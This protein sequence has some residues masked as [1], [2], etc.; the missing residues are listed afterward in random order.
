M[1]LLEANFFVQKDLLTWDKEHFGVG[2]FYRP[3]TEFIIVAYKGLKPR[4]LN[5]KN[6]ANIFREKRAKKAYSLVQKPHTLI[7][8]L[9]ELS[10][11][12]GDLVL[13]CFMCSG[14]TAIAS[15]N[16]NRRFIGFEINKENFNESQKDYLNNH[17]KQRE[18]RTFSL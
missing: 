2:F 1:D 13:D 10:S 11:N 3:Q 7:Q 17:L 8:K 5:R 14:T 12:E 15:R 9:I 16:T 6:Q 18:V 4:P